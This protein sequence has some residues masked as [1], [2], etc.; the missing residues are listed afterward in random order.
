MSS[1][2]TVVVMGSAKKFNGEGEEIQ[3][4]E[5]DV[6]GYDQTYQTAHHFI[7]TVRDN[8]INCGYRPIITRV[9]IG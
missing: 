9:V 7:K 2:K 5:S 6:F 8:L 3:I 1:I 4:F